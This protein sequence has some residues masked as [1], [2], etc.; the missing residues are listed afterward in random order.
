MSERGNGSIIAAMV[1]VEVKNAKSL[2]SRSLRK[3][4]LVGGEGCLR[5]FYVYLLRYIY[6]YSSTLHFILFF[7]NI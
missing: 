7:F 2:G 5:M 3:N 1:E 4:I 6:I